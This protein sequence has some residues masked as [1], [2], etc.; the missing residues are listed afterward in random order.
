[1]LMSIWPRHL[2]W[3]TESNI[4]GCCGFLACRCCSFRAAGLPAA[5]GGAAGQAGAVR[6]GPASARASRRQH[7]ATV[8]SSKHR[9]ADTLLSQQHN[10][11]GHRSAAHACQLPTAHLVLRRSAFFPLTDAAFASWPIP[12]FLGEPRNATTAPDA[13]FGHALSCNR[14]AQVQ[15]SSFETHSLVLRGMSASILMDWWQLR[16]LPTMGSIRLS[17]ASCSQTWHHTL[18]PCLVF[19]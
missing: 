19:V 13:L 4:C 2:Q 14:N 8:V 5:G 1:M 10:A 18:S 12:Y 17:P 3:Q 9:L 11:E 7:R 6:A 16:M 15:M